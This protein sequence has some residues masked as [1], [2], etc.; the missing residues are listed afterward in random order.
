MLLRL[1]IRDFVIVDRLEL[2]FSAGFGALTGE[3]GAGKS[4]LV[5]ALSLALGERADASIVRS[6][7]EKA[8]IT[9]EFDVAADSELFAWLAAHDFETDTCM[10][11]RVV[12]AAGKSRAWINGTAATLGQLREVAELL[13]DI[14]GQHAH[15]SLLR[16]EAQRQ[17]LDAHAGASQLAREVASRYSAWKKAREALTAA[18]QDVEAAQRE[19]EILDWQVKELTA[20]SFDVQSWRETEAEQKR[21][22]H[23]ASLLEATEAA[24]AVLDEG[25]APA[26]AALQQASGRL[27]ELTA[28]DAQLADAVQL[29]ESALIQL[30]EAALALRRYRERLDLDPERLAELDARIEAVMQLARKHRVPPEE[31]PEV[32]ARLEARLSE[33]ELAADP[34]RLAEREREAQAAYREAAGRL[35]AA[36]QR[37]AQALGEAVTA[38]MQ[39]LAMAGGRF[40]VAL[41]PLAEGAS[42]GLE[43]VE[44]LVAANAGQP[45]RPLAKVA[46]GGELSR[47]GLALQVIASQA[48][49][50]GTLIFDEVDVGIGGRVAEIV[51]QRLKELGA[52]RQ[53]LCVTHL[54]QVAARADWQWSIAKETV[55]GETRSRVTLLNAAARIEEIARMLGGVSITETTRQHAR[56]LLG[57]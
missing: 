13:C 24:L 18:Q 36:R 21:L 27:A 48:H 41:T 35:S 8:D 30:N 6:G 57:L 32:L 9:A 28:V 38:A 20:L 25:E 53:V 29:F 10:L 22:A 56:E 12:D 47:I 42:Y 50:A 5:D 17:L 14:H 39:E 11:R 43:N 7:A 4:I 51:G 33:L 44:F 49:P 37:A 34:T 15:H 26:L 46:S 40:E 1:S 55:A 45:L 52:H 2:E 3:T 19:K 16:V 23:A 31:L 54:P